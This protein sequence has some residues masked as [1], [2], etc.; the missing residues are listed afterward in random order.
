[1]YIQFASQ[2]YNK[3]CLIT[4][5]KYLNYHNAKTLTDAGNRSL[6]DERSVFLK[7]LMLGYEGRKADMYC[8]HN[9]YALL[10]IHP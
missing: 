6:L 10:F 9:A 3:C 4:A 1:M 8:K 7:P 5:I 2:T